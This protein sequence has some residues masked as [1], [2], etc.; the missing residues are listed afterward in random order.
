MRKLVV[1]AALMVLLVVCSVAG[2]WAQ[3]RPFVTKW[4]FE[5]N[6]E[7][8]IPIYGDG[9]KLVIA[10]PN[11]IE[12][13]IAA[14]SGAYTFTP[15]ET[16]EYTVK[17]GPE[18]VEYMN[19]ESAGGS[20]EALIE[21]VQFGTVEWTSMASTFRGCKNM[22][23]AASIDVPDLSKVSSMNR[24]F[25][26]C[27]A[28]NHPSIAD[29]NVGNV[30]EMNSTFSGC[31]IFNQSL[32][33][34]NVSSVTAMNA[35]FFYCTAFNQPLSNWDVSKVTDM[36]NMFVNCTAFNQSLINWRVGNVTRMHA[37][38]QGC[39]SFNQPLSSWNVSK[40]TTMG[41][42]FVNC[43]AFNQPLDRWDVSQVTEMSYMFYKCN[44]FNQP[45]EKWDVSQV[46]DMSYMFYGCN[47]FNQPLDS[48]DVSNVTNME[49][50]FSGCNSFNQP[51]EKWNVS[52]VSNMEY[53]FASCNSFN[54][55]LEKWNVSNVTNMEYMFSGCNSFNQP[56][57]NW[58]VSKVTNMRNMFS[59]C[60]SF[61]QP[62]DSWDVSNV[63]NMTS[64]F[65]FAS[66]FNQ[67]L[68]KWK[69][70]TSVGGLSETAM[71]TENYSQ[72][73]VDWAAQTEI[74]NIQFGQK[75]EGLFYNDAGKAARQTLMGRGWFFY[76]D[77]HKAKGVKITKDFSLAV[78]EER[79]IEIEKWGVT[80]NV[81]VTIDGDAIS[82]VKLYDGKK[83]TIKGIKE[84]NVTLKAKVEGESLESTCRIEV[85]KVA[86][87]ALHV[88]PW[89]KKLNR[90]ESFSL[91]IDVQPANASDKKVTI[92][93]SDPSV[94]ECNTTTGVVTAK[95]KKGKTTITVKMAAA[96]STI[97]EVRCEVEVVDPVYAVSLETNTE[98]G[99]LS[100]EGKN[101]EQLK[102][103]TKGTSLKVIA[104]PKEGYKLSSL[105][106]V[107]AS[108]SET[109]LIDNNTFSVNENTTVKATFEKRK[110]KVNVTKEGDNGACSFEVKGSGAD[111]LAA[112]V[113]GTKLQIKPIFAAGYKL[114][115][116]SV[117]G[118]KI[119]GNTFV[120][121]SERDEMNVVVIFT[122]ETFDITTRI[123][124]GKDEGCSITVN[125][126]ESLTGVAYGTKVT[127]ATT[128]ATGWKLTSLNAGDENIFEKKEF[129]VT[130]ATEVTAI[131]TK[132]ESKTYK[133]TL[134][135]PVHGT[136]A[137]KDY[138]KAALEHVAENTELTVETEPTDE[139]YELKEL[140][141]NETSIFDTKKFKVTKETTVTAV[142]G[143]QTFKIEKEI[144]GEGTLELSNATDPTSPLNLEAVPYGTKI[145]VEATPKAGGEWQLST[146]EA[147]T[148]NIYTTKEF[149]VT[150]PVTVKAV[151]TSK[152]VQKYAVQLVQSE[153]GKISI[154][155][156]T[157]AQ[158]A[159]VLEGTEL[160]V[161]NDP[162]EGYELKEIR[163]NGTLLAEP[164]F[165]VMGLTKVTAVFELKKFKIMT[166]VMGEGCSLTFKNAID[167]SEITDLEAVPYGTEVKVEAKGQNEDW[168]LISLLAGTQDIK[169]EK[170]FVVKAEVTVYAIFQN[171]NA[172]TFE[173]KLIQPEHGTLAIAGYTPTALKSV[174]EN[175]ELTVTATPKD[176]TYELKELK[177]NGVDIMSTKKFTVTA[178]TE[179]TAKF[180]KKG[181]N[182]D[183]NNRPPLAVEEVL[184]ASLTVSPNP[185]TSQLRIVNPEGLSAAYELVN[186]SGMV[187]RSGMLEGSEVVIETSDLPTGVYFVRFHGANSSERSVK[188]IKY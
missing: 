186:L 8:T 19:M 111:N 74:K 99:E 39:S 21:V 132:E 121:K 157:D 122:L 50:M 114:K 185:F 98:E 178:D 147:G 45:L 90:G 52:N 79:E 58:N 83:V 70:Q 94:A 109:D 7:V 29:W 66:S 118:E 124:S 33:G 38:F 46:T 61:N 77:I 148:A 105:K 41:N 169:A 187:V 6:K 176:D 92:T 64:M 136:L 3:G 139:G 123:I 22:T 67:P 20:R 188:V 34:W 35:M 60:S 140:K 173:V 172:K 141:A 68:G 110:L 25:Q 27:M 57:S 36:S 28:F 135:P 2:A 149:I 16:G 143:L 138:D 86:A 120:V 160:T 166:D 127:V 26:D 65:S 177:A 85:K 181:G 95:N 153:H 161:E 18:G 1:G 168:E 119:D 47:S 84:G 14:Q 183:N 106:A 179:V 144:V 167:D 13:E 54:Q 75:V 43:S 154:K 104:T 112:V 101:A 82:I 37:M 115:E 59:S 15:T 102:A 56:L 87:T 162:E 32:A 107:G 96:G 163:V 42:M 97:P 142:F 72:S 9:Y 180:E 76:G 53:M 103:V 165:K 171:K 113:Y 51:L 152:T 17:A 158:L 128:P 184:F 62:L 5:K 133:V 89:I 80:G 131:F 126:E 71:S 55:P 116:I 170:K 125:G 146:L 117:D 182:G 130:K 156:Y 93:N 145:K 12:D 69:I 137:I 30:T 31:S 11:G 81:K 91:Q 155:N 40:V 175:T 151:F 49:Y 48:W 164:T 88:T 24:M 78:N 4:K 23:F 63:T 44:S 73:L 174:A 134:T 150:A 108:G 10:D 100:I 159:E 129:T